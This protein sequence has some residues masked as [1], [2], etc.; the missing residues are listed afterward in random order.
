MAGRV[1]LNGRIL[2]EPGFKVIWGSDSIKVDGC[3]IPGPSERTYLLLNKPFGYICSLSDPEGRPVVTDLLRDVKKR[4]YPVGRLDFDSMG[5]LLLTD[6]GEWANRLT[7][8]RYHVTKTYKVT[9]K[10]M[11]TPEALS[12]L[13]KGVDLEDGFSGPA[14]TTVIKRDPGKSIIRMTI[15]SG[16]NRLVRRMVSAAGHEVIQLARIGFGLFE[17]GNLKVGRYR[18]LEPEEVESMKNMVK[19]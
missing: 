9:I 15:T 1:T 6:D 12:L 17:L 11:L 5:L 10:G 16:K 14:K 3:E 7:H 18:H 13:S 4:V 2:S 8:P 19:L